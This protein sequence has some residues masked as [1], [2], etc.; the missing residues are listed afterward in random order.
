MA[1]EEHS[2]ATRTLAGVLRGFGLDPARRV[3]RLHAGAGGSAKFVIDPAPSAAARFLKRRPRSDAAVAETLAHHAV[4]EHLAA[5]GLPV[6]RPLPTRDGGTVLLG[7]DGAYELTPFVEADRW[8]PTPA[9]AVEAGRT[10]HRLH[11]AL[12]ALDHRSL[13]ALRRA[14]PFGA[15]TQDPTRLGAKAD[16]GTE[17]G[18]LLGTITDAARRVGGAVGPREQIVH[19]DFHPGNTRWEGDRL[20]AVL[21]FDACRVGSPLEEAALASVH[22]SLDRTARTMASR[23]PWPDP[24]VLEGFWAGYGGVPGT[25]AA[26]VPW[27][28]AGA[29]ARETLAGVKGESFDADTLSFATGVVAWIVEHAD[30]LAEILSGLPAPPGHAGGPERG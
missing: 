9:R 20:V 16:D 17:A 2:A 12:A 27:L 23:S 26:A 30:G 15:P 11:A 24:G 21:D 28:A 7:P 5:W 10:L 29:F 18:F 4:R 22:F 1:H 19:G 25:G 13:P 3:R 6:H 8:A 14:A